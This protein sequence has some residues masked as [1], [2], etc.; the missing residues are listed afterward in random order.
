LGGVCSH[1]PST[2]ELE[3]DHIDPATK[4]FTVSKLGSCNEVKFWAEV[5]KCQLL[6]TDCHQAKTLV[7]LNRVSAKITHGTLSSYRYCKC[8]LCRKA[9]SDYSRQKYLEAKGA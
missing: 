2:T 5:D 4:S 9:K 8:D 3:L 6:C 1:C 7:D